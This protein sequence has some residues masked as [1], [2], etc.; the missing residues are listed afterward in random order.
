MCLFVEIWDDAFYNCYMYH[1]HPQGETAE[2][3]RQ[4]IGLEMLGL[5]YWL[6]L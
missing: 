6:C 1:K 2:L 4:S 5:D 3:N